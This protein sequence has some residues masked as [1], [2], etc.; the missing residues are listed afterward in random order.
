MDFDKSVFFID[1]VKIF[2]VP[3]F[4]YRDHDGSTV[5][6]DWK[7]GRAREG[8][9]DQVLGYALYL[10]DRYRLPLETMRARLVYLNDAKEVPV[11]LEAGELERFTQK[12]KDSVAQMR[13]VLKDPARNVAMTEAAFP[14][15]EDLAACARCVFRR[16]CQ[17]EQALREG[18]VMPLPFSTDP[19]QEPT[20]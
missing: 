9:D 11:Q 5:I 18:R 12:F 8:Y 19:K 1:G 15:T 16:P 13:G 6:V 17:R 4:A 20:P 2:A 14:R 10:A 3:D 7:T